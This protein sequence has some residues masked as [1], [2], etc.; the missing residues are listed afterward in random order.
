MHLATALARR[1]DALMAICRG[2]NTKAIGSRGQQVAE[3]APYSVRRGNTQGQ[4]D[5]LRETETKVLRGI[6]VAEKAQDLRE[7]GYQ[8]D[9]ILAH[10]G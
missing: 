8:P 3:V 1:G 4:P 7:Q 5:C 9:L 2:T 6:W 10:P